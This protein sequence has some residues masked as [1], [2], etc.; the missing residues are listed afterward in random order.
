MRVGLFTEGTY[1]V[2][3]GGVTRW[4]ELL[5]GGLP[6][7][8]FVPV[9][10]IGSDERVLVRPPGNVSDITLVPMWGPTRPPL[11]PRRRR[12]LEDLLEQVWSAALPTK[13]G[14]DTDV[15]GFARALRGFTA[16][17]GA[18]LSGML[19][20]GGSARALLAAWRAQREVRP[21]LPPLCLAD[22]VRATAHV[23]RILAL[24]DVS[25]PEFDLSHV[26]ANGPSALLALGR[27]WASGT[28]I[29][30]TEH[31]IYLRERYLALARTDLSWPAR[32][33][34]GAFMRGLSQVAYA[35]AIRITPVSHFNARWE[36]FLGADP[37]K[38]ETIHNGV[39][40][41]LFRPITT[42][43][44]EPTI[45]FVGRI[46]PLKDLATLISAVAIVR[47]Q[48]PDVRLR[49]FGPTPDGNEPYRD[50]LIRLVAES[51]LSSA[52]TFEGPVDSAV[53]ALEAGHVVALS[54]I[55]EG[56]P[57]T[58]IEAMMAGCAT[59]NTDVGGVAEVV[60]EDGTSGLL[61]PP[62]DPAALASALCELLT[63]H[64]RRR[65]IG[66]QARKRALE[67]FNL[68]LF[69]ERYRQA[70]QTVQDTQAR[71]VVDAPPQTRERQYRREL[72][73][74]PDPIRSAPMPFDNVLTVGSSETM[75]T[76]G[77]G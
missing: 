1:P 4:C 19:A 26:A 68:D 14:L 63:Q 45:S 29:L 5:I 43:P 35:E 30:L 33:A 76:E 60:G 70:Y 38:I 47:Q 41:D 72:E 53:P 15:P 52:V 54:S 8:T 71:S 22:A 28:P 56:L 40:T 59:V 13:E 17:Q 21:G 62:R 57:Y 16:W 39:E 25:F 32:R 34:I 65:A 64:D 10:I 51:G 61:V 75:L 36:R 9:T 20:A 24:A 74:D 50:E 11:L 69:T 66:Q 44:A 37:D 18:R 55:S 46:D 3:H 48:V 7:F 12:L 23:D 77:M 67:L 42:E 27:W 2:A 49:V 73:F 31:G 58:A 6:E